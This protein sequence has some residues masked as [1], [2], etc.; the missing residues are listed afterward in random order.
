LE[1]QFINFENNQ[2]QY[3]VRF[4]HK[5]KWSKEIVYLD[6]WEESQWTRKLFNIIW[7]I[8]DAILNEKILFIDEIE[9]NLHPHIIKNI[10]KIIHNDLWKNYQFIFTSHNTEFMNLKYFKKEQIWF[11][12][13]T[14][15]NS[16]L[17]Y[18]LYDFEDLRKENDIQKFYN[19]GKLWWIPLTEDFISFIQKN[20]WKVEIKK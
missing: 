10:F 5:I 7:P 14:K 6:L 3:I 9:S 15:E 12:D 17:F 20:L 8:F 11:T 4:W 19:L 1:K 2:E 18:T 16:G 13:K